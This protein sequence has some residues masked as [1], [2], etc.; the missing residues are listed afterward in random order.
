MSAP[1]VLHLINGEHYGG[2][3]RVLTNYLASPSRQANVMVGVFFAGELE[4]RLREAGV[5][6]RLISMKGRL[7][8]LAVREVR[9]LARE[10]DAQIIHTHQV[11]NT[12]LGRLAARLD[13][14]QVVT[15]VHSPAFRESTRRTRNVATGTIDR[16]FSRLTH[17]FVAVSESLAR[18]LVRSGIPADRIR[19][20]HNGVPIP[21]ARTPEERT[22]ARAALGLPQDAA[23]VGMV[24]LFRPRK[25]T[26]ILLRAMAEMDLDDIKT[27][28]V[29]IGQAVREGGRDYGA[30]LRE[31]ADQLG[32]ADRTL[33][34]GFREDVGQLLPGLDVVVLPS[35]FGEGLPMALLEAMGIGVPVV[36][37][38]VEGIAELLDDGHNGLLVPVGDSPAF[39]SAIRQL[40]GDPGLRERIGTEGRAT[41]IAGYG[42]DS[43][44]RKL[45]S[46][47]T[48]LCNS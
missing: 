18:E 23:A 42:V 30:E 35:L 5:P 21:H 37:T 20:V 27:V 47:Y 24:A 13:H 25:G 6:T 12:L 17:R 43:M 1:R 10:F 22:A 26:E 38:P 48:E 4:R 9:H 31:F 19:M 46:I 36:S 15:H 7:D 2:A 39:A 40:L 14:R 28:V 8:V 11:R 41:V 44:T 45:E 3:S 34:T 29:L 33:F 32:I 16:V